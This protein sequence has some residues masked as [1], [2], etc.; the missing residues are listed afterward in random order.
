MKVDIF[1]DAMKKWLPGIVDKM[2]RLDSK[3]AKL[4]VKK[5]NMPDNTQESVIWPS[6]EKVD[7]C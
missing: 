7:Y 2:E 3:N 6:P 5:E 1:D 4:V